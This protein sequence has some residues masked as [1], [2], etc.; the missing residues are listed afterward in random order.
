MYHFPDPFQ[1]EAKF[2][3]TSHIP[4]PLGPGVQSGTPSSSLPF[5]N[6]YPPSPQKPQ[7]LG[8]SCHHTPYCRVP[9]TP[10]GHIPHS[11][12]TYPT[13]LPSGLLSTPMLSQ[14]LVASTSTLR[15]HLA[16]GLLCSSTRLAP[17]TH[18][19][20]L[21]PWA[22]HLILPPWKLHPGM[23]YI[24]GIQSSTQCLLEASC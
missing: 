5:Q 13:P 12:H 8:M 11:L 15:I 18:S 21:L 22:S 17:T 20:Y 1:G 9:T 14:F 16:L 3:S 19:L 2:S 4:H 10:G 6:T 7:L 24:V 23:S